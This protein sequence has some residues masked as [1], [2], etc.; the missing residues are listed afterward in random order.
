[1][2]GYTG[3]MDWLLKACLVIPGLGSGCWGNV[4]LYWD[5]GLVARGMSGYTRTGDWLLGVFG[6]IGMGSG[7]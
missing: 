6:Y 4:W 2:S 5:W 3:T 1:M 7:C